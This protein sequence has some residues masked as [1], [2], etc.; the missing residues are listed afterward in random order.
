MKNKRIAIISISFC[1][2]ST[3]IF[4]LS[5]CQGNK[6]SAEPSLSTMASM[7]SSISSEDDI[8]QNYYDYSRTLS[9][10]GIVYLVDVN[11]DGIT[12]MLYRKVLDRNGTEITDPWKEINTQ[13]PFHSQWISGETEIY[14]YD[15]SEKKIYLAALRSNSDDVRFNSDYIYLANGNSI[16]YGSMGSDFG[17]E[18]FTIFDDSF[19]TDSFSVS[20]SRDGQEY[21]YR[22]NDSETDEKNFNI[23]FIQLDVL[24]NVKDGKEYSPLSP[25]SYV[26]SLKAF[27]GFSNMSKYWKEQCPNIPTN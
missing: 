15:T 26:Q 25:D 10:S 18:D 5:G 4:T 7:P 20:Y 22:L 27:A 2:L 6:S 24:D 16:L 11:N 21:Y 3:L 17:Y 23:N 9:Q 19:N 13:G 12:E 14:S 1:I 8:L